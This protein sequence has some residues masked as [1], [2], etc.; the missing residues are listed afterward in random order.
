[1]T[2]GKG[3]ESMTLKR[4]NT[5]KNR[6]CRGEVVAQIEEGGGGVPS[7]RIEICTLER[8]RERKRPTGSAE[9]GPRSSPDKP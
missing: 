7:N 2:G 1:M 4:T 5:E 6:K 8:E 9:L 3:G